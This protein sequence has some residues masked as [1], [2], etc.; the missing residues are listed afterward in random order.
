MMWLTF[1]GGVA[2]GILP[3]LLLAQWALRDAIK[4]MSETEAL[5]RAGEILREIG[6]DA[7]AE[8]AMKKVNP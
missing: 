6:D 8:R 3:G 2:V 7:I 1:A 4:G 5:R